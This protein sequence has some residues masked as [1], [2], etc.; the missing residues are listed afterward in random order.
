MYPWMGGERESEGGKSLELHCRK[1]QTTRK[2]GS[3]LATNCS[4][5]HLGT[6]G[7]TI[8]YTGT[9]LGDIHQNDAY[10]ELGSVTPQAEA[11]HWTAK[12]TTTPPWQPR[13]LQAPIWVSF[14]L[15]VSGVY[16]FDIPHARLFLNWRHSFNECTLHFDQLTMA[17]L[18]LTM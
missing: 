11:K 2:E 6:H 8:N 13:V 15:S 4:P 5:A 12:D 17:A 9:H 3:V 1:R 10:S 18:S 14:L 7:H 16:L